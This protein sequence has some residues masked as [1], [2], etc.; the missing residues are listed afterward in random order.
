MNDIDR[1]KEICYAIDL[2]LMYDINLDTV[3]G[4]PPG[5]YKKPTQFGE[6]EMLPD[7]GIGRKAKKAGKS[8]GAMLR[9]TVYHIQ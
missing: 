9:S 3:S 1:M 4:N 5:L 2:R 7:T 6:S 8:H